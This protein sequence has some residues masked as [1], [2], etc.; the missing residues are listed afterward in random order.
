MA[1]EL[2][3]VAPTPAD[4]FQL[5]FGQRPTPRTDKAEYQVR[6]GRHRRMVVRPELARQLE[7]ELAEARELVEVYKEAKA[8]FPQYSERRNLEKQLNEARGQRDQLAESMRK[9]WP[10]IE[11]DYYPN[12][13]TPPFADAVAEYRSALAELEGGAE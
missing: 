4:K 10:F 2:D 3:A 13:S 9:M 11:E 6:L 1:R 12:C 8:A 5:M 7:R